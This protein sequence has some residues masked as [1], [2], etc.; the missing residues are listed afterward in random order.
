[1]KTECFAC[2]IIKLRR[3]LKDF[4]P[5]IKFCINSLLNNVVQ[6]NLWDMSILGPSNRLQ[7]YYGPIRARRTALSCK[8]TFPNCIMR[9]TNLDFDII[10][11]ENSFLTS[12]SKNSRQ[13]KQN[14]YLG[15]IWVYNVDYLYQFDYENIT[16]NDEHNCNAMK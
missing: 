2:K 16:K 4:L 5:E 13:V 14:I 12:K 3:K 1:M 15:Y 6:V 7:G 11:K 9:E 10:C 8:N